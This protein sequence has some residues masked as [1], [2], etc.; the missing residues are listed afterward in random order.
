VVVI[1]RVQNDSHH[2]VEVDPSHPLPPIPDRPADT[3]L[4]RREQLGQ[5]PFLGV[6]HDADPRDDQSHSS[7]L[8]RPRGRLPFDARRGK[9]IASGLRVFGQFLVAMR[10]VVTN[11]RCVHEH[12][13]SL[14]RP[15]DRRHDILRRLHST[16]ANPRLELLVPP[17]R[18]HILA[19]QV[20]HR[21]ART[22]NDRPITRGRRVALNDLDFR[23]KPSLRLRPVA[24]EY[25]GLICPLAQSLDQ[26]PAD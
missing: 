7:R 15:R 25:N 1:N 21:L 18:H 5:R 8:N 17:S 10:T 19:R 13:R 4:E 24:S 20:H 3:K 11:R 16:I 9:K 23:P 6:Q 2:V 22:D 12:F 14:L 26:S